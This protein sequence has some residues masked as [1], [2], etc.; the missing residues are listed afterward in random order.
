MMSIWLT[1]SFPCLFL[2]GAMQV[3]REKLT[4]HWNLILNTTAERHEPHRLCGSS[5]MLSMFAKK[6]LN[7]WI[8]NSTLQTNI[9]C[10]GEKMTK[11]LNEM[12]KKSQSK[13]RTRR[14]ESMSP[15]RTTSFTLGCL[16][17]QGNSWTTTQTQFSVSTSMYRR[18]EVKFRGFHGTK[19]NLGWLISYL[20]LNQSIGPGEK[21]LHVI[22]RLN[23]P[24]CTECI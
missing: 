14:T 15:S 1:R 18:M 21:H 24:E 10:V 9:S 7:S 3:T 5:N 16:M 20:L 11:G 22:W 19:E 4:R 2:L 8:S 23:L 12:W 17:W 13:K 6:G